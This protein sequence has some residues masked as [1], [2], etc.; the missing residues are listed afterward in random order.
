LVP[1][2]SR[3]GKVAIV[4]LAVI[5]ILSELG[6][7]V[8]SLIA[9]LGIGGLAVALAAQKTM[10][11]LFG[12]FAIGIDQ[13]LRQ[14]DVVRI[15]D[16]TGTVESIGLR[17]T[18]IRTADRT[19]I[20]LPNGKLADSR[21][22]S[23]AHR[24]RIR[25]FSLIRLA[26]PAPPD[27][28]RQVLASLEQVLRAQPKLWTESMVVRLVELTDVSV[29]IEVMAW[30]MTTDWAEFTTIRQDVLLAFTGA[31]EAAD[32][33]LADTTVRAAKKP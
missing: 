1:L 20:T 10:E 21:I 29:N 4:S 19:L 17:S 22:E 8:G 25:F 31:I 15:D 14:G 27:Q 30:F 6:Y 23:Y 11:N 5:A 32:A 16:L 13:P 3:I 9:G 24:D 7:P 26:H 18:R 33:R 28:I 2:G 12:T